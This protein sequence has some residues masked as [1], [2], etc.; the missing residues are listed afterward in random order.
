[1]SRFLT[2]DLLYDLLHEIGW[3]SSLEDIDP[4]EVIDHA[5]Q[6]AALARTVLANGHE[7]ADLVEA[8]VQDCGNS[9]PHPEDCPDC[10][11]HRDTLQAW[12][13][14]AWRLRV[15]LPP[16]VIEG[17]PRC[18]MCG[19]PEARFPDDECHWVLDPEGGDLCSICS[20]LLYGTIA[21]A[22][23]DAIASRPRPGVE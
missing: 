19:R 1:M 14:A 23:L 13:R 3:S 8:D 10:E 11:T 22:E 4:Q 21:R 6:V 20:E 18:R 5:G 2:D 17:T 15:I 12:T 7:L 16:P 9:P